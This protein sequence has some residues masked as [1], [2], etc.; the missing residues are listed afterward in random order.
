MVIRIVMIILLLS[1]SVC[2]QSKVGTELELVQ[3]L[4]PPSVRSAGM[5][6]VGVMLANGDAAHF[7]PALLALG[8]YDYFFV[9]FN[10]VSTKIY[11]MDQVRHRTEYF[12][13]KLPLSQASPITVAIG[14]GHVG[15]T[16]GPFVE[17]TYNGGVDYPDQAAEEFYFEEGSRAAAVGVAW[18]GSLELAV[19]VALKW[20]DSDIPSTDISGR[21][22]DVGFAARIP[23][24]RSGT[25]PTDPSALRLRTNLLF[26][27]SFQNYGPDIE[28]EYG[29]FRP[30]KTGRW[31]IG[32]ELAYSTGYHDWLTLFPVFEKKIRYSSEHD[33][34]YRFG[35]EIGL[36][37]LLLL[38][39]GRVDLAYDDDSIA[40]DHNTLGIGLS[41]VGL[42]KLITGDKSAE[43]D[44]SG[45]GQY[46]LDNL[47]VE[48]SFARIDIFRDIFGA[49]DYYALRLTL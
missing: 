17:G 30:P 37:E 25:V 1:G 43:Q 19:G 15:L 2:S 40:D 39:F 7:N 10:P 35:L 42:R 4:F 34:E 26:G 33:P 48:F 20:I 11:G 9:S 6:T 36:A 28:Y 44:R 27:L 31:G 41:T 3:F 8:N 38:R 49:T 22:G 5:G 45:F 23:M 32:L 29:W 21:T 47:N 14:Y 16:Y 24:N 12:S 13:A 18:S 46:L